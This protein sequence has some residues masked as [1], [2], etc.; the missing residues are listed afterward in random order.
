[1]KGEVADKALCRRGLMRA[2]REGRGGGHAAC[3]FFCSLGERKALRRDQPLETQLHTHFPE[4]G[5]QI[6]GRAS[7]QC[8]FCP[9]TLT[10]A[11]AA[12]AAAATEIMTAFEQHNAKGF[13]YLGKSTTQRLK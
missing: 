1:M 11:V 3:W 13:G 12:A 2:R 9:L 10:A 4:T 8:Y 5:P 6:S 7:P